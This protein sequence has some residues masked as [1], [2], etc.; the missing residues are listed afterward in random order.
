MCIQWEKTSFARGDNDLAILEP[1]SRM[2]HRTRAALSEKLGQLVGPRKPALRWKKE[3]IGES[4]LAT[5]GVGTVYVAQDIG[6]MSKPIA[7]NLDGSVKWTS[8]STV[9]KCTGLSLAADGTLYVGSKEGLVAL[10]PNGQEEWLRKMKPQDEDLDLLMSSPVVTQDAIYVVVGIGEYGDEMFGTRQLSRA[11]L[12]AFTH[13][14]DVKWQFG[15]SLPSLMINPAPA[16]SSKGTVHIASMERGTVPTICALNADGK[17]KWRYEISKD[18]RLDWVVDD[19]IAEMIQNAGGNVDPAT[20]L[21]RDPSVRQQV[22]QG[23]ALA[24][25]M[26]APEFVNRNDMPPLAVGSDGM[27]YFAF[28]PGARRGE[29]ACAID[30]TGTL[31]WKTSRIRGESLSQCSSPTATRDGVVYVCCTEKARD[32]VCCFG[33]EGTIKWILDTQD[34]IETPLVVDAEGTIFFADRKGVVYAL[35]A[36]GTYK[37]RY[38]ATQEEQLKLLGGSLIIGPQRMLFFAGTF[39]R[40]N[41]FL[42]AI[43]EAD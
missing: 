13:S 37:W 18:T 38:H 12:Y 34:P 10:G 2:A 19:T 1:D 5:D 26:A 33:P 23:M 7:I 9:Q 3:G 27:V 20:D 30:M 31:N 6:R 17:L 42:Y 14:G 11:T 41:R 32:S 4:W 22:R 16:V 40:G 24:M 25:A 43:G 29:S 35:N 8:P 28:S 21:S 36:D 15:A 39:S